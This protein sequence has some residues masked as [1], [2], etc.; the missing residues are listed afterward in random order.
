MSGCTCR[1]SI[2]GLSIRYISNS[3]AIRFSFTLWNKAVGGKC[4][5]DSVGA[6]GKST[7]EGLQW[8]RRGIQRARGF[9]NLG[10]RGLG[11]GTASGRAGRGGMWLWSVRVPAQ[12]VRVSSCP[13]QQVTMHSS[14]LQSM[15][16]NLCLRQRVDILRTGQPRLHVMFCLA[17]N[18]HVK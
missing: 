9:G 4:A 7:C 15:H 5:L 18:V 12:R 11:T 13:C 8:L 2:L 1:A 17:L 6:N 3:I 14:I 10:G 16:C